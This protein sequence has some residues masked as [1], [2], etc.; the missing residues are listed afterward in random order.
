MK[1]FKFTFLLI[2]AIVTTILYLLQ[3]CGGVH[4]NSY[5]EDYKDAAIEEMIR[6]G[7]PASIKLAQAILESEG[8]RSKLAIDHNNHFGMLCDKKWKGDKYRIT[9]EDF[10]SG[11]RY[12]SCY[13]VYD[14]PRTSFIDH[15]NLLKRD[16]HYKSLFKL[17]SSNYVLWA[18]RLMELG[19]TNNETY[20]LTLINMIEKYNLAEYDNI[21]LGRDPGY[22]NQETEEDVPSTLSLIHI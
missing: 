6:T 18:E 14:R 1:H 9:E 10:T 11:E 5:V 21:A 16:P 2:I 13:K 15:T 12:E 19:Y 7:Y 8:G 3:S 17:K 22:V 4:Y 20:D